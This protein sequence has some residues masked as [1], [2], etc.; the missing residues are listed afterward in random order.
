[1]KIAIVGTRG[2]PN[3]YGGFET[4]A[5]YLAEYLSKDIDITVFCSSKDIAVKLS[6]FKGAKLKYIPITSHGS[7]GILYDSVSLL[8]A[9][10]KYEKILFL[11]FG[12]GFIIPFL[13]RYRSKIILN[14]GGLDWKRDKWS[15]FAQ[16]VI[17]RAELLLVK[18][19]AHIVSDN[20]A[21]QQYIMKEYGKESTL[22]AYG[23]DQAQKRDITEESL[24][25]Y[26]FLKNDYAFIVT[27]IQPDNNIDMILEA[28]A[29]Q[30]ALPLVMV[31]NWNNSTY[32]KKIK[33]KYVHKEKIILV[34]AIYNREKLDIL[35]SNCKLYIHGHSAGGTN[36]SLVEAMYLGLPVFAFASGYNEYTTQNK[37]IYFQNKEELINLI[38]NYHS[39]NLKEIGN[40]LKQIAERDYVWSTIASKYKEVILKDIKSK[41]ALVF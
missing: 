19:S 22:I 25:N 35:R 32:G 11:G 9:V 38:N 21:I 15:P 14:I 37:A 20:I 24:N 28:F 2:I 18:H 29:N 4:L 36:P 10:F 12:G 40:N 16:K 39:I 41:E 31:G 33:A 3:N 34:D 23:G 30:T 1:M 8:L 17:K 6:H 26:S 5:E 13:K 27:R 7:L